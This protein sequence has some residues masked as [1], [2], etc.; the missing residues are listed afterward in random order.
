MDFLNKTIIHMYC[1][2]KCINHDYC[3]D[4][5]NST[6]LLECRYDEC[7]VCNFVNWLK[8]NEKSVLDII[9]LNNMC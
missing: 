4:K 2:N 3:S 7:G 1:N 6:L 9:K 8:E 5:D